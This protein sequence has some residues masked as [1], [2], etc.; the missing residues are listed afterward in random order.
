MSSEPDW[1]FSGMISWPPDLICFTEA[2]LSDKFPPHLIDLPGRIYFTKNRDD[3]YGGVLT[4]VQT[5]SCS[6]AKDAIPKSPEGGDLP[7][8]K[9]RPKQL[10]SEFLAIYSIN[11][12]NPES[13]TIKAKEAVKAIDNPVH[14]AMK[15]SPNALIILTDDLNENDLDALDENGFH[16]YV[17]FPTHGNHTLN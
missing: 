17:S 8:L 15:I 16:Q 9:L 4:Y 3:G 7:V 6:I 14:N 10:P 2:W 1:R 13:N 12:Y 5:R 11:V